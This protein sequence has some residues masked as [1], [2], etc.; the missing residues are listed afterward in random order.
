[1]VGE[2]RQRVKGWVIRPM[3]LTDATAFLRNRTLCVEPFGVEFLGLVASH[4]NGFRE[5]TDQ[6]Y[7]RLTFSPLLEQCG[8]RTPEEMSKA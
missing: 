4:L 5:R 1:M 8:Y 2:K 6:A 3:S 7:L